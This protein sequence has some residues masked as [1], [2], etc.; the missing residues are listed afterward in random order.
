[1]SEA[2]QA[3]LEESINRLGFYPDLVKEAVADGILGQEP[4]AHLVQLETHF[5]SAQVHRHITVL[6]L[7][8]NY[9]LVSHLDDQQLDDS[10]DAVVAHVSVE[11]LPV[12][13]IDSMTLNY[14]YPQPHNYLP[15]VQPSEISLMVSW[16]GGQRL[17]IQ[18]ADCP[19][20]G[21]SADHG[22]AGLA[23]REDVVMRISA[24]A[25]GPELVAQARKFARALRAA[26]LGVE[27]K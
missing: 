8:G 10:A 2:V 27:Q 6:A 7:A 16:S 4:E 12:S 22:Y 18:P 20:P 13:A 1:M 24:T 19:D 5:E 21:C 17:D 23:S 14:S 25:D 9:L 3:T 15:G 11:T 26:H